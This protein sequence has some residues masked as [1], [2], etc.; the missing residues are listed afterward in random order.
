MDWSTWIGIIGTPLAWAV[1]VLLF[2]SAAISY[3]KLHDE[4]GTEKR[5]WRNLVIGIQV[6]A[7]VTGLL[8]NLNARSLRSTVFKLQKTLNETAARDRDSESLLARQS[9]LLK[10]Q[11][12]E[13]SRA[14]T[15]II[16]LQS[17]SASFTRQLMNAAEQAA[18]AEQRATAVASTVHL[19]TTRTGAL[20]AR[21][22]A[23][24]Q[25]AN[26]RA[27]VAEARAV[28]AE[29]KAGAYH[30]PGPTAKRMTATLDSYNPGTIG[31]ACDP[32]LE[33]TCADLYQA[34]KKSQWHASVAY[35]ALIFAPGPFDA[36]I[37]ESPN[38]GLIVWYRE[39]YRGAAT[40]L[41][42]VLRTASFSVAI[43]L[44]PNNPGESDLGISLLFIGDVQRP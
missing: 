24:A 35:S 1:S 6:L 28:H 21:A 7:A 42:D 9:A 36:P 38:D 2:A 41:A 8:G 17:Q 40:A 20:L 30:L 39:G 18:T 29:V 25:D 10:R 31:I 22:Q 14:K 12:L 4:R 3:L 11:S 27:M 33:V 19:T 43:R 23:E 13:I 16:T 37:N 15:Q 32:G 44:T 5:L 26:E 34:A